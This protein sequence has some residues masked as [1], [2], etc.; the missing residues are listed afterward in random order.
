MKII[1]SPSKEMN[2]KYDYSFKGTDS[3]YLEKSELLI[4]ALKKLN[5][6]K[7][8]KIFKLSDKKL[9]DFVTNLNNYEK[10]DN[11][12]A[13]LAYNG[14]AFRQ[15]KKEF[16][17]SQ[18]DYINNNVRILSALY[19][20]NRGTDLIKNHRLD[21]TNKILDQSMY[22]FWKDEVENSKLI[23]KDDLIINLAS[24]EF[25]KMLSTKIYKFLNIDFLEWRDGKLKSIS[26][27]SKKMRGLMLNYMIKNLIN[28]FNKLKD[29][30][31]NGYLFNDEKSSKDKYVFIKK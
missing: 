21:M 31:E 10:L 8:K 22:Q 19:G 13:I 6:E 3:L 11:I 2:E 16:N 29:F 1:F 9:K 4:K 20:I 26:T 30:K 28:D 14:I 25:S 5:D 17:D 18:I 12:P 23:N 27:N 15:I 24:N 7:I